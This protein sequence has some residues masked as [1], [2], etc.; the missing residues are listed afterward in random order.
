MDAHDQTFV[1]ATFLG[2]GL[3]I[4][5]VCLPLIFRKVPMN[6]F[7][8]IRIRDAFVSD[9]RWYDINAYG[10]KVLA[11]WSVVVIA[12]GLIGFAVPA[13]AYRK[14]VAFAAAMSLLSLLAA[15]IQTIRW[16]RATR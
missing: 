4:L 1:A 13:D 10:G 7:Y 6:H 14:Y 12:V 3:V 9:K 11:R 5:F 8:G 15:V 2:V 16:A